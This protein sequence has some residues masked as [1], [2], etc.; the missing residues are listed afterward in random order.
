MRYTLED[1]QK[2]F[3]SDDVCLDSLFQ[4]RYGEMEA[5]PNCGVVAPKYYRVKSRT[6][7]ECKDC[8]HQI[9]PLVGTI[10]QKSTTPL[11]YW[12]HAMYMLLELVHCI[13]SR[14]DDTTELYEWKAR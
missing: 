6:A 13:F 14:L 10:F 2:Q 11:R 3:P 8:R 1:M 5:C 4:S 9:Y 12:W 7:Y